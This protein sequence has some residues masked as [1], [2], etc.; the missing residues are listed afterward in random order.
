MVTTGATGMKQQMSC[1]VIPVCVA[2]W[3]D[4]DLDVHTD[5]RHMS[6]EEYTVVYAC[7]K[8]VLYMW[9]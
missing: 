1:V 3:W 8:G 7:D 9:Q 2:Y 5:S 6:A 4:I